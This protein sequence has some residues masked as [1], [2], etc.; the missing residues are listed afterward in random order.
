MTNHHN[1]TILLIGLSLF[2]KVTNH[3][4][5]YKPQHK[6]PQYSSSPSP[7]P[8][9]S[10][11]TTSTLLKSNFYNPIDPPKTMLHCH[12]LKF[13]SFNSSLLQQV[14]TLVILVHDCSDHLLEF[15]KLLKYTGFQNACDVFFGLFAL[16][17]IVTRW[18]WIS[19]MIQQKKPQS[20]LQVRSIPFLDLALHVF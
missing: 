19:L 6:T 15:A 12:F 18:G 4:S 16:T 13:S 1:T 10:P 5:Q 9:T 20:L 2:T 17:W 7:G 11:T 14:G 3:K 8:A